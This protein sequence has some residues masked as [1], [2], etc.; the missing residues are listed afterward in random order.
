MRW[1]WRRRGRSPEGRIVFVGTSPFDVQAI[2][3]AAPT[4][5]PV[6]EAYVPDAGPSGVQLG[7]ADGTVLTLADDDPRAVALRDV[8]ARLTSVD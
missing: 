7:L 8:A 4:H 2:I 6:V 5:S 3:A 1:P